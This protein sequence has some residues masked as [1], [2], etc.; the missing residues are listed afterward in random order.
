MKLV[1]TLTKDVP[2]EAAAHDLVATVKAKLSEFPDVKLES[3]VHNK[4]D[5]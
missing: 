5:S 4:I 1:I 3:Y 2:D